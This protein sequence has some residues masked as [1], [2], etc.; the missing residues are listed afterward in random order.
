MM[1]GLA[2]HPKKK[3]EREREEKEN[4]RSHALD[5]FQE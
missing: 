1:H 5:I 3:R 4:R 2:P